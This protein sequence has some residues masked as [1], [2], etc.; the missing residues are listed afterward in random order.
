[1][2]PGPSA[3]HIAHGPVGTSLRAARA[4]AQLQPGR[5]QHELGHS[6]SAEGRHA[7]Q[8][9][10][11]SWTQDDGTVFGQGAFSL[12]GQFPA[13]EDNIHLVKG[14]FSDSIPPFLQ[15]QARPGLPV[16][17]ILVLCVMVAA[18]HH[19]LPLGQQAWCHSLHHS[20]IMH[21]LCL[22]VSPR[23]GA[24]CCA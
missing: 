4:R 20:L 13:V 8:G 9:L 2:I 3:R 24:C 19:A 17:V 16:C 11:E 21:G 5:M 18:A 14:L 7:L 22:L 23:R 10:P 12:G 15:L 6:G 1:M